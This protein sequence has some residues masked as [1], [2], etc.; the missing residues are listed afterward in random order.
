MNYDQD[1]LCSQFQKQPQHHVSAPCQIQTSSSSISNNTP[2]T[3][4]TPDNK[5]YRC[6]EFGHFTKKCPRHVAQHLKVKAKIQKAKPQLPCS[7][8]QRQH[9]FPSGRVN[10]LNARLANEALDV[11]LGTLLVNSNS[12]SVLFDSSA[13]HSFIAHSFM[14]KHGIPMC[15]LKKHMTVSSPIGDMQATMRC[16]NISLEIRG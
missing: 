14:K 11:V 9:N 3:H 7:G 1:Q 8:N 6:G 16:P 12:A 5:C 10:Y 13:S 4:A 15:A 2:N